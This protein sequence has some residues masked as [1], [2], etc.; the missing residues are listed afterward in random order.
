MNISSD[1]INISSHPFPKRQILDPLKPKGFADNKF[2]FDENGRHLS[3]WVENTEG[4]I[5]RKY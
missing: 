3:K 2:R 5:L 1:L 4:K